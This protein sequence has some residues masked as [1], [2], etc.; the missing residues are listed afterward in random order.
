ML[1][2]FGLCFRAHVALTFD[3]SEFVAE[4]TTAFSKSCV[5]MHEYL[6]PELVSGYGHKESTLRNIASSSKEVRFFHVAERENEEGMEEAR[7]LIERL[8]VKDP[9][10]RLGCTKGATEIKR[11]PFFNGIKLSL[12]RN[13]RAPLPHQRVMRKGKSPHVT[14]VKRQCGL[15]RWC[16]RFGCLLKNNS[17][18]NSK[19]NYYHYVD[20][21]SYSKVRKCS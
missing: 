14:H 9:R 20:S 10:R 13:Y 16:K 11:H 3:E 2:D 4:P 12:I 7:D 19:R 1:S 17:K 8:L 6:A 18:S 15:W 5:G 21:K